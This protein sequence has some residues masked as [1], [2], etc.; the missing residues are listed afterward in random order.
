M[1]LTGRRTVADDKSMKTD[2][3]G[4]AHSRHQNNTSPPQ[5]RPN[6]KLRASRDCETAELLRRHKDDIRIMLEI[7][8]ELKGGL[9]DKRSAEALASILVV[10]TIKSNALNNALIKESKAKNDNSKIIV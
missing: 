9:D 2:P 10:Q 5:G 3:R 7:L 1:P 8:R 4:L 6:D